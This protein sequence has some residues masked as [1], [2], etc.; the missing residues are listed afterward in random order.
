MISSIGS[1]DSL[2]VDSTWDLQMKV[3]DNDH[4]Y[5]NIELTNT[6]QKISVMFTVS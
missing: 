3:D 5:V 6:L 1:L 4:S 2:C